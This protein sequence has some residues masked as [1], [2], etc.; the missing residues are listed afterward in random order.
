MKILVLGCK[1]QLGRC[2]SDQLINTDYEV[3]FTSRELI[4]IADFDQTKNQIL[5]ILPDLIINATAYTAVDDAEENEE[6]AD[7]INHLAVAHISK[8][9]TQIGCWLI[10]LSTDY[11]FDG[12]SNAPY[13]EDDKTNPQSVYGETK[14]KGEFAIKA[15]GCKY[16]ILRTAWVFSEH[17]NNFLKTM[18]CLGAERDELSIVGDQVGNPTYAQ[19]IAKAI[20]LII[21]RLKSA[22]NIIGTYHYVG[23]VS[24]SWAAF[25]E[26]IFNEAIKQGIIKNKPKIIKIS[27]SEFPT[28]AKRPMQSKLDFS[29]FKSTF[30]INQL[31]YLDSIHL[32]IA[33]C[34]ELKQKKSE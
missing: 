30:G 24:C 18:L 23:E 28:Q 14:L 10:H 33:G 9:C 3:I 26:D 8:I 12:N 29:K 31:N 20:I 17:G 5:K 34:E 6:M 32:A 11:V 22:E 21:E 15:S 27:T 7:L 19:D 1:G 4:N 25:A 2:L 16:I 13:K